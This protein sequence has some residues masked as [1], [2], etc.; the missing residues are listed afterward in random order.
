MCAFGTMDKLPVDLRGT[1]SASMDRIA[2]MSETVI[3]C[4]HKSGYGDSADEN[5]SVDAAV[6][7]IKVDIIL[8]DVLTLA[9]PNICRSL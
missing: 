6:E 7:L 9:A 8:R 1:S 3:A 4:L 2:R 5:F